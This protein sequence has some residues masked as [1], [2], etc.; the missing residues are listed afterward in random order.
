MGW[1]DSWDTPILGNYHLLMVD[2]TDQGTVY[3]RDDPRVYS[4]GSVGSADGDRDVIFGVRRLEV[5]PPWLLGTAAPKDFMNEPAD[6]PDTLFFILDTR[7]GLRE[8]EHSFESLK[9]AAQKLGAPLH[10]ETVEAVYNARRY[11]KADLLLLV[12]L[13]MPPILACV[14]LMRALIR[15]CRSRPPRPIMQT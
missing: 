9:S 7:T 1:G 15:L 3:D 8:D 6:S 2:D 5:R 4:N 14:F 11:D 13:S 10:L 12:L